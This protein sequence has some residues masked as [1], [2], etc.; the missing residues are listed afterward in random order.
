MFIAV[1][2][3]CIGVT[4]DGDNYVYLCNRHI[5]VCNIECYG[6]EVAVLVGELR[7]CKTHVGC[8]FIGALCFCCTAEGEVCFC[9]QICVCFEII[10]GYCMF[11]AVIRICL[12][13]TGD[14]NCYVNRVDCLVTVGHFKCNSAE[15]CV[16]IGELFRCQAHVRGTDIGS[17]SCSNTAE[18]EVCFYIVQIIVCNCCI[19]TYTVFFTVIIGCVVCTSDCD[20]YFNR[21][22]NQSGCNFN[23]IVACT[24]IIVS[25]GNK[26]C[27]VI[28]VGICSG[29]CA[30]NSRCSLESECFSGYYTGCT[31]RIQFQ[32]LLST[33]IRYRR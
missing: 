22:N 23:L 1:I 6:L 28:N 12:V 32:L 2:I 8:A 5:T 20:C 25:L 33:C 4:G 11:R 19:T 7:L 18:G 26:P 24:V 30:L 9:I 13:M 14:G 16:G 3:R 15:V 10:S 21:F 29:I 31:C 27:A 17:L